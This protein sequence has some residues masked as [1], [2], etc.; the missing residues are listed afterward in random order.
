[1]IKMMKIG[2]I[3]KAPSYEQMK[4]ESDARFARFLEEEKARQAAAFAK[5]KKRFLFF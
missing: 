3:E 4:A 1:M 2:S 5:K